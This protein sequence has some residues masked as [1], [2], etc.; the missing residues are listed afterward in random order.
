MADKRFTDLDAITTPSDADLFALADSTTSFALSKKVSWANIK[1]TIQTAFSTVFAGTAVAGTASA[2]LMPA[3]SGVATEFLNGTGAYSA[4]SGGGGPQGHITN[5]KIV[6]SVA[7][8]NITVA[9]KNL[10]N[11]DPSAGD[12]VTVRIGDTNRTITAALS[13]TK[14]AGTNWF[15]SGSSELATN[16]QDY[17]VY[18]GYNATDGVVIG[19]SRIPWARQYND[20]STSSTDEKYCAI[21]TI[22]NAATTDYYEIIGRFAATLSAGA[23]YT[24]SVPTF[25]AINLIQRPIYESRWLTWTPAW[26][27]AGSLTFTSVSNVI[28]KYKFQGKNI[29]FQ[30]RGDGT[31]G[32]SAANTI[33]ATLPFQATERDNSVT[34][35]TGFTASVF[36]GMYLISGT[37]DKGAVGKYDNSNYATSGTNVIIMNGFYEPG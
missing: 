8:N 9:I 27:A 2:G 28:R 18:L 30:I 20:F 35:A 37:P 15:N 11:N 1:S 22:T 36:G 12:P 13:V 19:F 21:S 10:A 33:Y 23:G 6:V 3:L 26:T 4:P 34:L 5:G 25:T 31:L 29:L 16:E 32:G 14:N 24:W 7:S 17:F